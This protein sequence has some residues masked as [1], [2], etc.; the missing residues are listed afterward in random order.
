MMKK[1]WWKKKNKEI[2]E[3]NRVLMKSTRGEKV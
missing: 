2:K 1:I 3:R